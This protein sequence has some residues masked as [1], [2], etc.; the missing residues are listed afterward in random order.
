MTHLTELPV[1]FLFRYKSK[2]D[3]RQLEAPHS[4][5]GRLLTWSTAGTFEGPRLQGRIV[6]G[7]SSE[8]AE[9]RPDGFVKANVRL[10]LE[11]HD[12]GSILM[13]YTATAVPNDEGL[14]VRNFPIFETA[15]PRYAWLNT[16]QAITL[17]QVRGTDVSPCDVYRLPSSPPV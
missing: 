8:W 17:Y 16:V 6:P 12:G 14:S 3:A 5:A 10:L 11:T 4:G 9:V 1:E 2:L 13:S 7:P 15:D